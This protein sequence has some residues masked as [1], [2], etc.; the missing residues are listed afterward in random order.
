MTTDEALA[1]LQ[2]YVE[3]SEVGL[4]SLSAG[5]RVEQALA[6]VREALSRKCETCKSWV[7]PK[8]VTWERRDSGMRGCAKVKE[9]WEIEDS[10]SGEQRRPPWEL[11][12][13]AANQWIERRLQGLRDA[14][15]YV[16]DGSDY[17]AEL[18]T[19]PDFS[20]ALWEA[21]P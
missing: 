2:S 16:E 20:C 7:D 11:G 21:K 18:V 3:T 15:A 19:G 5:E 1:K 12:E 8:Q 17:S 6:V 10:V 9:R 14:K 4:D 13:D